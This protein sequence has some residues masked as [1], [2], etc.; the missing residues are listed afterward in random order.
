MNVDHINHSIVPYTVKKSDR[1]AQI[2]I[3]KSHSPI[4]SITN[5]LS[6]TTHNSDR[7]GSTEK[8]S[9]VNNATDPVTRTTSQ[10]T[11]KNIQKHP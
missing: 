9:E 10:P 8:R 5:R 2:I 1:I 3:E 7:F 4:I 6:T 11:F